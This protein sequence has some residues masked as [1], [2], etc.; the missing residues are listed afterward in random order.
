MTQIR[1]VDVNDAEFLYQL[2][3]CPSVLESLNEIP[4]ER[5]DWINA[6]SE[7]LS[8]D[9]EEDYIVFD[10]SIPVGWLGINGLLGE[11]RTAYLKMAAFLP[12]YQG[13]GFGS[14]SIRELMRS[15]KLR[16][17]EKIVLFTDQENTRAQACYRKCGFRVVESLTETMSNGKNVFR[18][19][20]EG[21]L[22]DAESP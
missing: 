19:R 17:I 1:L 16:G 10:G 9:D 6:I 3:N 12:G 20:M 8:D 5:Q 14:F 4:T 21:L 22:T 13:R 2:M 18:Y 15:L 11:D 7:W